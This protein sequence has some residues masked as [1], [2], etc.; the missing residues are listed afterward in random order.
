MYYV[1]GL[2][3]DHQNISRYKSSPFPPPTPPLKTKYMNWDSFDLNS[4]GHA[5]QLS[6][7]AVRAQAANTQEGF[8]R[9]VQPEHPQAPSREATQD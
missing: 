2:F 1:L 8:R 9:M 6:E 7:L 5:V 4:T 3:W